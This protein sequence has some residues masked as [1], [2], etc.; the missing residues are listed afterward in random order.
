M[1]LFASLTPNEEDAAKI[2]P[3]TFDDFFKFDQIVYF[4]NRALWGQT[5]FVL[6][7]IAYYRAVSPR[8]WKLYL[9]QKLLSPQTFRFNNV[10]HFQFFNFLIKFPTKFKQLITD[11]ETTPSSDTL[12]FFRPFDQFTF[13]PRQDVLNAPELYEIHICPFSDLSTTDLW[14]LRN[15]YD[16]NSIFIDYCA[17]LSTHFDLIIY[18][19]KIAYRKANIEKNKIN[20]FERCFKISCSTLTPHKWIVFDNP[21]SGDRFLINPLH[22]STW[23]KLTSKS[24]LINLG[25]LSSSSNYHSPTSSSSSSIPNTSHSSVVLNISSS[26]QCDRFCQKKFIKLLPG[27]SVSFTTQQTKTLCS[28][29][30]NHLEKNLNL[31]EFFDFAYYNENRCI[32]S[33]KKE[34]VFLKIDQST[35]FSPLINF[36]QKHASKYFVGVLSCSNWIIN[37]SRLAIKITQSELILCLT[38]TLEMTV[39]I[40]K[41]NDSF[42]SDQRVWVKR[43][44]MDEPIYDYDF[45]QINYKVYPLCPFVDFMFLIKDDLYMFSL[46]GL[47]HF[48]RI[49]FRPFTNIT[50]SSKVMITPELL[51]DLNR[52]KQINIFKGHFMILTL[53]SNSKHVFPFATSLDLKIHP[54]Y[55]HLLKFDQL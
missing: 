19:F 9:H 28:Y 36:F 3:A 21:S 14:L 51:V 11:Q 40:F 46:F 42:L 50:L 52:I 18:G 2:L 34:L 10:I 55:S 43:F 37:H 47:V 44:F 20:V 53:K 26:S 22:I 12:A 8:E 5:S 25:Y 24:I 54:D 41:E 48:Q 16:S 30:E 17:E 45:I 7:D 31:L 29:I 13:L 4:W 35:L 23:S 15:I 6:T 32:L 38:D 39:P 1:S 49:P 27:Q 33:F